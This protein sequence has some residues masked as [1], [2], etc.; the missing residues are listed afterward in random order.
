M[1]QS[2]MPYK[3]TIYVPGT[4]FGEKKDNVSTAHQ[5]AWQ[6]SKLFGGCTVTNGFGYWVSDSGELISEEVYI[7]SSSSTFSDFSPHIVEI[8]IEMGRSLG[9][10][11]VSV[12]LNGVLTI[13]TIK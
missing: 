9:Q 1:N 10:E 6:M 11:A 12:E 5:I 13:I 7:A 8:A 2:V 4:S 3:Y